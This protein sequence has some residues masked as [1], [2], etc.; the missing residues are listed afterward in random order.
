MAFSV[1]TNAGAFVAL[2]SLS[3]TQ[4]QLTD[5]QN[6]VSTGLK[7][8]GVKDDS[9]TFIIAQ[10]QRSDLAGITA[11]RASLDRAT[12]TLD[13]AI[14]AGEA[15]S[16]L[17]LQAKEI[18]AA[19]TDNG[20]DDASRAALNDDFEAVVRQMGSIIDQA[21]F[22]GVNLIKDTP[23]SINALAGVGRGSVI[24]RIEV[25]GTDLTTDSAAATSDTFTF[26]TLAGADGIA[27]A[28]ERDAVFEALVAAGD[29]DNVVTGGPGSYAFDF[30]GLEPV[31]GTVAGGDAVFEISFGG[32]SMS[33][34]TAAL[35]AAPTIADFDGGTIA[36]SLELAADQGGFGASGTGTTT[37]DAVDLTTAAG[38][39]TA[40]T[41]VDN[42]ISDLNSTLGSFGA[43]GQQIELQS[44]FASDLA[45]NVEVGIGKLVDADL[46]RESAKLQ[47]L[48]V[49]QQLGLAAAGIANSAPQAILSLF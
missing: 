7:V 6:R 46:A 41:V 37:L 34:T 18:A 4:N 12:G 49:Q 31:S 28:A 26:A 20:L 35:G 14:S 25:Q 45:D 27:V 44:Q 40:V 30:S 5:T 32:G 43:K 19:A 33:F 9:S 38:R 23:D 8:A 15:L 2:Q 21:D 29:D 11:A 42:F 16:D 13:V 22:N 48:Q 3:S 1:N 39:Q 47:A 24:S 36:G 10:N 17:S